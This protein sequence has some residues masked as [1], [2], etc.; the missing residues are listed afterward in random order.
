M[1]RPATGRETVKARLTPTEATALLAYL[2]RVDAQVDREGK[3]MLEVLGDETDEGD[4]DQVWDHLSSDRMP[5]EL[6]EPLRKASR[7]LPADAQV[8]VTMGR[9]AADRLVS[10]T[11]QMMRWRTFPKLGAMEAVVLSALEEI[12]HAVKPLEDLPDYW[13]GRDAPSD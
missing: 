11:L 2:D 12:H 1:S 13:V 4:A 10:N 9:G 7:H 8:S 5:D 3:A 6:F